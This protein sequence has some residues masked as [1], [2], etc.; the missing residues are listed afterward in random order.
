MYSDALAAVFKFFHSPDLCFLYRSVYLK[1]K[2]R[3]SGFFLTHILQHKTYDAVIILGIAS[4]HEQTI[5]SG[6][7]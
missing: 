5:H 2:N 1:A 6:Q 7:F 3:Y 4:K